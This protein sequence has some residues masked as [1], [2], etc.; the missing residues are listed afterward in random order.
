MAALGATLPAWVPTAMAVTGSIMSV[1]GGNSAAN[2][3]KTAGERQKVAAEFETAQLEQNAGQVIASSQREAEEQ[4]RQARL[5][6]SRALALAG[7]SGG[8]VTDPSVVN[9]IG[10]IA[11]EGA[12]RAGVALYQGQDKARQL[13]MAA[14]AKHYEGTVAQETAANKAKAYRIQGLTGAFTSASSMFGKYGA[15]GPTKAPAPSGSANLILDTGITNPMI[16]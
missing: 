11:G 13:G 3:A 6:Q 9:L 4:R 2:A 1:M 14:A 12:Y 7:A 10:D 15:G 16:G 8:G 5:V